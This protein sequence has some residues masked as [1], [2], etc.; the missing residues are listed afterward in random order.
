MVLIKVNLNHKKIYIYI[1][2]IYIHT[3][4]CAY[5]YIYIYIYMHIHLHAHIYIPIETYVFILILR[6]FNVNNVNHRHDNSNSNSNEHKWSYCLKEILL[7]VCTFYIFCMD[8]QRVPNSLFSIWRSKAFLI[9]SIQLV[10]N[11]IFLGLNT[12]MIQ[13]RDNRVHF[14]FS[15]VS[16]LR[17]LFDLILDTNVSLGISGDK[18]R[19]ILNTSAAKTCKFLCCIETELSLFC[20]S[21]NVDTLSWYFIVRALSCIEF[22]LLLRRL[23]WNIQINGQ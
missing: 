3:Y 5:T 18:P 11:P 21:W 13:Y 6:K 22:I 20:S 16:F 17:R 1:Y 15:K 2:Y 7:V 10:L 8:I 12:I 9:V 4:T 19:W 23:L 14:T